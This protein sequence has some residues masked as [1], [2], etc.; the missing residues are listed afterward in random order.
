M[1]S[2]EKI[3][4]LIDKLKHAIRKGN[5]KYSLHAEIRMRE[6]QIIKLEVEYVLKNG[7]HEK[8]KD[9]FNTEFE[10]WDYAIKGKT[11]DGKKLRIIV[12]FEKPDF[13]VITT[14][15]LEK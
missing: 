8:Q 3:D 2:S 1:S 9:S 15:V 14:I 10:S 7:F 4:N 5:L 6:R 12:G 13:L 11:I